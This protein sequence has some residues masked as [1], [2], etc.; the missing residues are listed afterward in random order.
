MI[1]VCS[2]EYMYDGVSESEV[3]TMF[4]THSLLVTP[5]NESRDGPTPTLETCQVHLPTVTAVM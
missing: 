3:V 5:L 2:A 1:G 4:G